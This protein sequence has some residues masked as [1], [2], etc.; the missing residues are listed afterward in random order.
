MNPIVIVA[1]AAVMMAVPLSAPR[2]RAMQPVRVRRQT[3]RK[4]K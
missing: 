1:V 2:S 3:R 4:R